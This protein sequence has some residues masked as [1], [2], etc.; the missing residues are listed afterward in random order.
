MKDFL[1]ALYDTRIAH[2][3]GAYRLGCWLGRQ[4]SSLIPAEVYES[5]KKLNLGSSNRSL[6]GY[7]NVDG[8]AER[9]PDIV[10]GVDRLDFASDNEY[11]L[12]RASHVIEHFTVEEC[13]A[14]LAEWRR[15]L[16]PGGWLVIC[17]PDYIRLSW[18][19][20]LKR[21][22]FD[23]ASKNYLPDWIGG[24]FAVDL[25]PEFRLKDV[26]TE[27]S[28]RSLLQS[29]GFQ[30]IGRQHYLV[31]HPYTLGISDDSCNLLSLNLAARKV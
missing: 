20:I 7:V 5:D 9:H 19:A 23:P 18:R 26:F 11:D 28:L 17:T 12:V 31:E 25:P 10:S 2:W 13:P 22:R 4:A 14:V 1:A 16:K 21:S 24:L 15:V 8:L 6:P 30:V 29:A 27:A 3:R